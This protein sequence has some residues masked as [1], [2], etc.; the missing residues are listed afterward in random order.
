[1][2]GP[3]DATSAHPRKC[4]QFRTSLSPVSLEGRL[5]AMLGIME[6]IDR[7]RHDDTWALFPFEHPSAY[8]LRAGEYGMLCLRCSSKE[9]SLAETGDFE[10]FVEKHLACPLGFGLRAPRAAAVHEADPL[11]A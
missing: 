2:R 7:R 4:R 5:S 6:P 9:S 11:F 3:G 10:R 8:W 1:M